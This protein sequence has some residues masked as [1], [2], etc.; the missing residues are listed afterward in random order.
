MPTEK[1][2]TS[3]PA[4]APLVSAFVKVTHKIN[5]S[6]DDTRRYSVTFAESGDDRNQAWAPADQLPVFPLHLALSGEVGDQLDMTKTYLVT[7][8]EA[9]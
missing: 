7:I 4:P 8:I 1:T 2:T 5:T 6:A 9:S 3:A